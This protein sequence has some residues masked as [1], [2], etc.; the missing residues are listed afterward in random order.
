LEER[1]AVLE[2]R[3]GRLEGLLAGDDFYRDAEKSAFYLDE[4]REV[5]AGL[6]NAMEE[7]AA[8]VA[9]LDEARGDP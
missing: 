3:K 7:W 2:E 9:A 6:E 4:Y 1:I 5:G 8:A